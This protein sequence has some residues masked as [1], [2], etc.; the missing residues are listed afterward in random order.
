MSLRELEDTSADDPVPL[1]LLTYVGLAGTVIPIPFW[2]PILTMTHKGHSGMVGLRQRGHNV[3]W[4]LVINWEIETSLPAVQLLERLSR[5]WQHMQ[6]D[7]CVELHGVPHHK[8]SLILIYGPHSK[9][10]IDI[11]DSLVPVLRCWF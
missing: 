8:P 5:P 9:L 3:V 1:I 6:L 4:W 11:S 7:V 10:L 2:A